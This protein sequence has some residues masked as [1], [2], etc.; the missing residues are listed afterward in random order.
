MIV[1]EVIFKDPVLNF[2]VFFCGFFLFLFLSMFANFYD[3]SQIA[4]VFG[5]GELDNDL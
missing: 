3:G 1:E 4:S 5:S 2:G